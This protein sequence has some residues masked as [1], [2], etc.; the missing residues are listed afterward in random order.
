MSREIGR[1]W[2]RIVGDY[3]EEKGYRILEY[4]YLCKFGEL[5]IVALDEE[6]KELLFVEVKFRKNDDYGN[7]Y[8]FVDDMKIHKLEKSIHCYLMECERKNRSFGGR[9]FVDMDYRLDVISVISNAI[10]KIRR[11]LP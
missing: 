11:T 3:L 2:E 5:D 4:N 9:R 10:G 6:K 7:P 8:E 1:A